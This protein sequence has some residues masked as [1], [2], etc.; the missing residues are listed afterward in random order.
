MGCKLLVESLCKDENSQVHGRK[1][2][3]LVK[4]VPGF[5]ERTPTLDTSARM[6]VSGLF[7][8]PAR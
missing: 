7:L 5:C 4:E 1:C 3:H 8:R 2:L 6:Q